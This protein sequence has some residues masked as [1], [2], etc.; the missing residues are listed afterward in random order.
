MALAM[1][2]KIPDI[3]LRALMSLYKG[4]TTIV[5]VKSLR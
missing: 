3:L 5:K 4:V 1:R 2:K